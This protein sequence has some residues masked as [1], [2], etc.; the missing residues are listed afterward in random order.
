MVGA[1]EIIGNKE[2]LV[3]PLADEKLW[4]DTIRTIRQEAFHIAPGGREKGLLVSQHMGT[5]AG[6]HLTLLEKGLTVSW[7]WFVSHDPTFGA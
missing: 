5:Y 7:Q 3:I 6:C 4:L 2:G 1:A